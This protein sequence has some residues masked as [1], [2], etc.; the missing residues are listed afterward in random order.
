F[1]GG[2]GEGGALGGGMRPAVRQAPGYDASDPGARQLAR[3]IGA[4]RMGAGL[5]LAPLRAGAAHV[6]ALRPVGIEQVLHERATE[7]GNTVKTAR[8]HLSGAE[9]GGE[10]RC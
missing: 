2:G 1:M 4:R 9:S 7:F 8:H 10:A 3:G 6:V 5:L